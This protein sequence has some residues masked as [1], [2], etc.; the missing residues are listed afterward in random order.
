MLAPGKKV[1][2]G[3]GMSCYTH[4]QCAISGFFKE[5]Y[6]SVYDSRGADDLIDGR[7]RFCGRTNQ[8]CSSEQARK[9]FIKQNRP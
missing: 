1:T 9:N 7:V 5:L 2:M 3:E 6:E 8:E 4:L